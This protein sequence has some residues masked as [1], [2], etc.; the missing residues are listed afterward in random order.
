MTHTPVEMNEVVIVP[1]IERLV[2]AYDTLH[3]SPTEQTGDNIKLSLGN[4]LPTN[5]PQLKENLM[6]QLELIPDNVMK[7]Q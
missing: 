4:A 7:L 3:D 2:Q 5:I 6:S 1:D